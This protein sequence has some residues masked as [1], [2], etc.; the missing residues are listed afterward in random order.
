MSAPIGHGAAAAAGAAAVDPLAPRQGVV[1]K[2]HRTH[3]T[4]PMAE[5]QNSHDRDK[6]VSDMAKLVNEGE[7]VRMGGVCGWVR[8]DVCG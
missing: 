3:H 7:W 1:G 8:M 4:T 2:K 5:L 6:A